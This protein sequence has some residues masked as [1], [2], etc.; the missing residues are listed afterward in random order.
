MTAMAS[1]RRVRACGM[2]L[3]VFFG[4]GGLGGCGGGGVRPE[5]LKAWIGRPASAIEREWGAPTRE[6]RDGEFRILIYEEIERKGSTGQA[7]DNPNVDRRGRYETIEAAAQQLYRA[8]T[9]YVRSYLFWVDR[10]GTI[11]NSTVR[12]P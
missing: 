1:T 11:V 8:P 2:A 3:A 10:Q 5:A 9:V 4:L 7:F 6:T 12:T